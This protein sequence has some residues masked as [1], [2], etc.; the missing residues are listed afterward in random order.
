MNYVLNDDQ[1]AFQ[2]SLERFLA[3]QA[4]SQFLHRIADDAEQ[5][6]QLLAQLW[7]DFSA[8]GFAGLVVPEEYGGAGLPWFDAALL[9]E[10]LGAAAAP[11]PWLGHL[12]CCLAIAQAGS[13]EQKARWLPALAAGEVVGSVALHAD[14]GWSVENSTLLGGLQQAGTL[15]YVPAPGFETATLVVAG[16]ADGHLGLLENP[17]MQLQPCPDLTRFLARIELDGLNIETLDTAQGTAQTLINAGM[18]LLAADSYGG[19]LRCLE[20]ST[21][22]AKLREQFGVIIGQFQ[23][24]KHQLANIALD[25]EPNRAQCW[26]AAQLVSDDNGEAARMAALA[27]VHMTDA[28]LRSARSSVE[29][30]GGFG[31]TWEADIHFYLKRAMFNQAFL[32]NSVTLRQRLA[33][34]L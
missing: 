31:Y 30:H 6:P 15:D 24:V 22:Y 12:L 20:A 10:T 34:T 9:G 16:L 26:Y 27:K 25:V 2:E 11:L 14:A 3:E 33:R 7:R 4:D 1:R 21:E 29:L 18:T 13:E 23:A 28:Y 8:L 32:G 19:S 5:R 17:Q